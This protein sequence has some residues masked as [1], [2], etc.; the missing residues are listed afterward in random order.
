MALAD[1]WLIRYSSR[2]SCPRT[3]LLGR[4]SHGVQPTFTVLP[5]PSA[6]R[7][8]A[9]S[10][11]PGVPSPSAH[12]AGRVHVPGLRPDPPTGPIPSATVPLAGF[13]SL[14][15][16]CSSAH[17]PTIFRPVTLVGF[18][19]RGFVLSRSPGGSSPPACLLD[20][21]SRQLASYRPRRSSIGRTARPLGWLAPASFDLRV[22]TR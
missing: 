2:F 3:R 11:S 7:L 10:T 8:S 4:S 5:I 14:S 18:P 6:P 17:R 20:L 21:C 15:T 16:A 9:E 22:A 19:Y 12:E 1:A 13:L